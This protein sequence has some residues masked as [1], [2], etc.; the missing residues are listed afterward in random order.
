MT[1]EKHT[2][3]WSADG[4]L[5]IDGAQDCVE[6]QPAPTTDARQILINALV[7]SKGWTQGYAMAF[8]DDYAPPALPV[9]PAE[10]NFC[11]RC[12]QRLGNSTHIHTCSLPESRHD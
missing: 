5:T 1:N 10:R 4:V 2:V 3:T 7:A 9:Q 8:V 12:G 6:V 11:Q